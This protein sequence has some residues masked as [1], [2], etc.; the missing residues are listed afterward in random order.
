[1][2]EVINVGCKESWDENVKSYTNKKDGGGHMNMNT[3][4]NIL[5][6]VSESC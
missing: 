5:N 6:K 2:Q 1:L 4:G 3:H